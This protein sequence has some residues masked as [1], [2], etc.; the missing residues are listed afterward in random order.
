MSEETGEDHP[1]IQELGQQLPDMIELASLFAAAVQEHFDGK[2]KSN[3]VPAATAIMA[4]KL[5]MK[6]I[7]VSSEKKDDV[8]IQMVRAFVLHA[9]NFTAPPAA[10]SN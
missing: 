8:L 2:T 1:L 4:A 9:H 7:D 5:L 6:D 10:G 3:L